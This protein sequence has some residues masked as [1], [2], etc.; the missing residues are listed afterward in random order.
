MPNPRVP[1]LEKLE[2][3]KHLSTKAPAHLKAAVRAAKELRDGAFQGIVQVMQELA[4]PDLASNPAAC[5]L[6]VL[7]AETILLRH[8]PGWVTALTITNPFATYLRGPL[9]FADAVKG[10][11]LH[12]ISKRGD[13]ITRAGH[14]ILRCLGGAGTKQARV[15]LL[16]IAFMRSSHLAHWLAKRVYRGMS[17]E[18][19]MLLLATYKAAMNPY[20]AK[21]FLPDRPFR[22]RIGV[23][24]KFNT[25]LQGYTLPDVVGAAAAYLCDFPLPLVFDEKS[26][27]EA[28]SSTKF[29]R[30]KNLM[31]PHIAGFFAEWGL[32]RPEDLD[33]TETALGTN[34]AKFAAACGLKDG[35]IAKQYR[36]Y[37]QSQQ[38]HLPAGLFAEL[39]GL[40]TNDL[41]AMACKVVCVVLNFRGK[42]VSNWRSPEE[43]T[44]IGVGCQEELWRNTASHKR[45]R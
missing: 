34:T 2:A 41:R 16:V 5:F 42:H 13:S 3:L 24:Q 31:L 30:G 6:V 20:P 17:V 14:I 9:S 33:L 7:L 36:A 43:P 21:R 19:V 4:P 40:S 18:A 28:L 45:K 15:L 25:D 35:D 8:V 37:I 29:Q 10:S 12:S 11:F 26:L 44:W 39:M 32:W 38:D 1:L 23:K 22:R 27:S